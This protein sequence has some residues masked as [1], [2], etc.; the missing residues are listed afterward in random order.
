M[1]NLRSAIELLGA[2][3][4]TM[5]T[6]SVTGL[7]NQD[8]FLGCAKAIQTVAQTINKY[9]QDHAIDE[10]PAPKEEVNG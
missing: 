9:V 10:T 2:V 7:E 6:I 4:D 1:D 3:R 5:D 8:R